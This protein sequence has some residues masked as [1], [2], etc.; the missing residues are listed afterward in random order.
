MIWESG[1]WKQ[2]LLKNADI[3]ERWA[4]KRPTERCAFVIEEK[5]FLS[6]YAIRRLWESQKLS[7]SFTDRS[8]KCLVYTAC[9]DDITINNSHKLD[10]LYD[11]TSPVDR[12]VAA[13]TFVSLIIHSF[14][15]AQIVKDDD[16]TV[17]AFLVTSDRSRYK[18]LWQVDLIE[19][20]R[21][22]R[23]VGNDMPSSV[24]RVFDIARND[25]FV[26]QGDGKP[27]AHVRDELR[28]LRHALLSRQPDKNAPVR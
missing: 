1:P 13:K 16:L 14:I 2:R 22:M 11:W 8:L 24:I 10:E 17:Q 21:L 23:V 4:K 28:R 9:S 20:V 6:A 12:S 19:F 5:V 27:P 3:I 25:W 7:S 18:G 26:W 15:F